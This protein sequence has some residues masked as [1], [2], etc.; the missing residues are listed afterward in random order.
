MGRLVMRRL[1]KVGTRC[2]V[3]V[4][5]TWPLEAA[6]RT[7]L[8]PVFSETPSLSPKTVPIISRQNPFTLIKN[9]RYDKANYLP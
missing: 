8:P 9:R 4:K 6:Q 3:T 2:L 7:S 1:G 5:V